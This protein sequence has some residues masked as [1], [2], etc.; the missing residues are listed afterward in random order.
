MKRTVKTPGIPPTE[1]GGSHSQ[2]TNHGRSNRSFKYHPG[3]SGWIV[4]VQPTKEGRSLL[5]ESHPREWVVFRKQSIGA[6]L[7]SLS[8]NDP[9]TAVR[10]IPGGFTVSAVSGI[11]VILT[12]PEH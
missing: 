1:V 12:R 11:P 8:M 4:Q 7:G 10:G 3:H 5:P 2:P 9:L 6:F